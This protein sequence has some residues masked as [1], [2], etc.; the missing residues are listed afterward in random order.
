MRGLKITSLTFAGIRSTGATGGGLSSILTIST[1]S[2]SNENSPRN[3]ELGT[4]NV[5]VPYVLLY[6]HQCFAEILIISH[7]ADMIAGGKLISSPAKRLILK[8]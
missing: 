1:M 8:T 4:G 5:I 3:W 7:R 2:H 6:T